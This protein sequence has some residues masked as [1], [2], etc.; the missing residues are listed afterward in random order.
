MFFL[1]LK[2]DFI[3]QLPADPDLSNSRRHVSGAAYSFVE[4][5]KTKNPK[6]IHVSV[7]TAKIIGLS[8]DYITNTD[9]LNVFTGNKVIKNTTPFA[10]CYGGHQF[11]HWAGQLGD[12]RAINLTEVEHQ[13]KNI[14][15][16]T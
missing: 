2:N 4:T 5:K 12:G 13:Q 10:M 16:T 7:D 1:N 9:F 15:F 8:K 11:G 14:Y 3:N 6:L